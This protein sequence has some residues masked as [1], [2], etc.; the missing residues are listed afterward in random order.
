[1]RYI[2]DH[3]YH[4]HSELSLCSNDPE[5]TKERILAYANENG[6]KKLVLTN[7]FWD[8]DVEGGS[9]WYKQQNFEHISKALPL[10]Q[11]DG[12]DFLFGCETELNKFLTLGISKERF[13]NF[14]F[15]IIPTTHLHMSGFTIDEKDFSVE[16]RAK[17]WVKRL[18]FVLNQD[19]P[20]RKIGI[21]HLATQ[22]IANSSREDCLNALSLIDENAMH[23]LF[24]KAADL[25]VGIELNADDMSFKDGEAETVLKMF[26]IAKNEGCKFYLGSD[27]H[28]PKGL[29]TAPKIFER[30]IDYLNL[31]EEDKF[32]I[33]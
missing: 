10:P 8:T 30:A 18:D 5:Q 11:A 4:I 24:K 25:G 32:H 9:N 6:L 2:V 23:S 20:F 1:M 31:T 26:R 27:A 13:N 19:L 28:H 29:E 3:D 14:D 12:I 33:K 21:A 17:L 22:L 15:V 16:N 7:H